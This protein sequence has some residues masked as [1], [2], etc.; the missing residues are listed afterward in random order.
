MRRI[1]VQL[2]VSLDG[3][4]EGPDRD[5]SW[6]LITEEIHTE[7]N[8]T[9]RPMSALLQGRVMHEMMVGYWPTA[10]QDPDV[11]EPERDFAALY[12]EMPKIVYSS[13][14]ED[15]SWN[16][17]IVRE[18]DPAAVQA[19]KEQ[20]G[21][22]LGIGGADLIASFQQHG[23]IDEWRLYV[24]PVVLGAGRRLFPEG[25]STPLRLI[26]SRAFDNGVLLARYVRA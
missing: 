23:L 7:F 10:D 20:P 15:T 19:M 8:E 3:Y 24:M 22:D 5:L 14:Y 26:E 17:T 1:I 21:G 2:S 13:T 6:H 4:F 9:I 11:S 18:V 16:T 25:M 12:R